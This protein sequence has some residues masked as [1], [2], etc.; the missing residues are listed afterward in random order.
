MDK[1]VFSTW[2]WRN[3][4]RCDLIIISAARYDVVFAYLSVRYLV[5]FLFSR[6]SMHPLYSE[7]MHV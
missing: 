2:D 5:C 7:D 1:K 4:K 3:K 6:F